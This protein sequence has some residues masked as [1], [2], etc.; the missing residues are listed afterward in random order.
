MS[1]LHAEYLKVTRRKLFP[2]MTLILGILMGFFGVLFFLVLPA[3][4]ESAGGGGAAVVPQRPAAFIFGAQ[5]VAGQAWWFAVILATAVFGGELATTA[6]ATSLARESR[7]LRHIVSK[8]GVFTVGSWLALLVGTAVW[9]IATFL[10]ADG[11]GSLAVSEWLG[12]VWKF[13]VIAA[14]WTSIGLGAIG[15][16]RSIPSAMAIALGLSFVDSILAPFVELYENISLSAATNGIFGLASDSPFGALI[17]G[18]DMSLLQALLIMAGW[19]LLGLG[20]MWWGL[21]RRDA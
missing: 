19:V 16:T 8:F 13:L 17:P 5:Q 7:K 11:T 4:P 3:L 1:L 18:G 2:V 6:W 12:L 15:L 10:F 20:L 14:A 9:S 21:Q